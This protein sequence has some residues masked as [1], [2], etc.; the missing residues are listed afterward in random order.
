MTRADD[1]PI[2]DYANMLRL[3]GRRYVVLGSGQG[4]GRQVAHALVQNGARIV[5]VDRERERS[6]DVARE[7][8]NDSIAWP[9]DASDRETMK[10][11]FADVGDA[12]GGKLDGV[13]D[14]VGQAQYAR[15][16]E[17]TNDLWS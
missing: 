9:G 4:M 7:C 5:C 6:E 8:G 10:R 12:F 11:L 2:P 15:L 1:T 13:V 3:D 17:L 14:I 16:G